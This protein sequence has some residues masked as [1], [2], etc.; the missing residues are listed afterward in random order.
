VNLAIPDPALVL[1]VGP[2]GS[3]KSTFAG[4]HFSPTEILSSD[5]MRAVISD[6]PSDQDASAEA[7]R[8]LAILANGRLKR[9]LMTVIDATNLRAANRK[10]YARVAARYG[11]PTLAIAFDFPPSTYAL[12]NVSR[13]DRVVDEDVVADQASRM[14][15]AMVDLRLEEH[16]SLHVFRDPEA[17]RSAFVERQ[18]A[19]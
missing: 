3:G 14:R 16:A 17:A 6:D 11:I 13:R 19:G 12:H 5:A 2:S 18:R 10:R 7:F 15:A 4:A 9:R 8:V 1:L